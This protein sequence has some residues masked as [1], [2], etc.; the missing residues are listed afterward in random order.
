MADIVAMY[1]D[2]STWLTMLVCSTGS[3]QE[4]FHRCQSPVPLAIYL[5][6]NAVGGVAL[7]GSCAVAATVLQRVFGVLSEGDYDFC[8][9]FILFI[10]FLQSQDGNRSLLPN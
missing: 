4:S 7:D 6:C 8:W 10:H 5:Q 9:M 3:V 1:R 2:R